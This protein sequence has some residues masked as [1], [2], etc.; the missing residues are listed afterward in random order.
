MFAYRRRRALWGDLE[1]REAETEISRPV[2][3]LASLGVLNGRRSVVCTGRISSIR[4]ALRRPASRIGNRL[5][6]SWEPSLPVLGTGWSRP[7]NGVIP[8]WEKT[9]FRLGNDLF[10]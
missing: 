4:L 10:P 2:F 8:A 5:Y 9:R 1:G 7:G 6:P 3:C